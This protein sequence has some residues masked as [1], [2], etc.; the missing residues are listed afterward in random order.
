VRIFSKAIAVQKLPIDGID[1]HERKQQRNGQELGSEGEETEKL[2]ELSQSIHHTPQQQT[3]GICIKPS[4]G[5]HLLVC[6]PIENRH[7][8][9]QRLW[10]FWEL[11]RSIFLLL[12]CSVELAP[13]WT[14][15]L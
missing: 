9:E 14:K 10:K 11:R 13:S 7:P 3:N 12:P 4:R 6:D 15:D 8:A 5:E 1:D 2:D